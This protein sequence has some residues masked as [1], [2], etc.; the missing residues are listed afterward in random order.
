MIV[1]MGLML[2]SASAQMSSTT[3]QAAPS[4]PAAKPAKPAEKSSGGYFI[5]FRAARIGIYGHSYVAYGRLARFENPD[6]T[7][8]ED[9]PPMGN[10][11]IRALGHLVPVPAN[12][13]WDPEVLALPI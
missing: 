6:P 1:A 9:R 10:Y 5:E 7:P 3:E 4:L 2:T 8:Y 11:A 12:T 13:E